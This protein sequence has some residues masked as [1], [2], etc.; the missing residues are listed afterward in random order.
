MAR[1]IAK[2]LVASD[3]ADECLVQLAYCIGRVDPVSV[4]VNSSGT[5]RRPDTELASL[6][7]KVFPLS[8]KGMIDH[9]RLRQPIFRKSATYGHFGREDADFTWEHINAIEELRAKAA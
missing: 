2:N 8:P 6:V 3:L 1:Y 5:G 4:M 7:R 9:L